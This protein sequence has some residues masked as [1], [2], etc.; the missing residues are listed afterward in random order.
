MKGSLS[1]SSMRLPSVILGLDLTD[2]VVTI[3]SYCNC[4]YEDGG[5]VRPIV[6][7]ASLVEMVRSFCRSCTQ[8]L[9]LSRSSCCAGAHVIAFHN[10]KQLSGHCDSREKLCILLKSSDLDIYASLCFRRRCPM[11]IH[12]LLSTANAPSML[13]IVRPRLICFHLL[14]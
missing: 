10:L 7:R 2:L 4:R 14:L 12:M 6:H 5:V 8:L 9:R 1:L 3:G 11:L 13:A